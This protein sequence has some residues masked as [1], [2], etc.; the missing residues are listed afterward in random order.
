MISKSSRR[1][2]FTLNASKDKEKVIIDFLNTCMDENTSIKE[3][4]YAYIVGNSDAKLVKVTRSDEKL[5]TLSNLEQNEIESL[6]QFLP[7]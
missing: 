4:L 6:K 3:I 7:D 5:L 2:Q 1:V